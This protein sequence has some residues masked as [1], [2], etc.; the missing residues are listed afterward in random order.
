MTDF[1]KGVEAFQQGSDWRQ[2]FRAN[3]QLEKAR[4][5]A[6]EGGEYDMESRRA[7]RKLRDPDTASVLGQLD[8]NSVQDWQGGLQDPFAYKLMDWFKSHRGKKKRKT[9]AI[10][11][12]G[13]GDFAGSNP[14]GVGDAAPVDPQAAMGDTGSIQNPTDDSMAQPAQTFPLDGY[15]D[16]G[17]IDME[18]LNAKQLRQARW[19]IL[20][21]R[22][23]KAP[24]AARESLTD[25]D[26]AL[27]K[28]VG[29][30]PEGAGTLRRLA[31]GAKGLGEAGALGGTAIITATTPT[32]DYR[33]RFGMETGD[34]SLAGDLTARTLGAASDLGSVL[35]F[36]AADRLYRDKQDQGAGGEPAA[37]SQDLASLPAQGGSG[38][39]VSSIR[40]DRSG[41]RHSALPTQ[42]EPEVADFSDLDIDAKEVP[43][44]KTDDWRK[45]RAQ[46]TDAARKSGK[47]EDVQK[48]GDMVTEMQ[49]KGFL[50]YG[51]QGLA[52]QQAGNTRG[53]MAAYRAAFQY[54]P[55]GNDVE[56]G[57]HKT[58]QGH[59][60]IVGVG[61]DEK[62]GKRVPGTEMIMDPE[63]ISVLMENFKNPAAF[64]MW[65]KDH[66]EDQ[67]R[68]RTYQEVTKPLAQGQLD[69]QADMGGAAAERA[70]ITAQGGAGGAAAQATNMRNAEHAFRERL[71]QMGLVDESQA[72]FLA[73]VMSRIKAA[74]PQVP[75][76]VIIQTIMAA[77][78]DG[79]LEKRLAAMA[80]GAPQAA[81]PRQ[82][83]PTPADQGD[84]GDPAMVGLNPDEIAWANTP[85]Q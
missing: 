34:P 78:K 12:G 15:A 75:D 13:E 45:Y 25:M 64:R 4:D 16:G 33:K 54:F 21:D 6:L 29:R 52:L 85:A 24:G 70:R 48:A 42:G 74:S 19:E 62:T 9:Q 5:L 53:A 44:M 8:P 11:L 84:A 28:F 77:A 83:I 36:G 67:Q 30:A 3:K 59:P 79:S 43:D 57:V 50:N 27:G 40:S 18:A 7:S 71:G 47:P 17:S 61:L 14:Q 26:G 68:E 55:N 49:I 66:R 60:Q 1:M 58:K 80:G 46:V 56:F 51:Q 2:R 31:A 82:A 72:D 35:T 22:L 39:D 81:A 63:R 73:S 37:P 20:K 38:I 23:S 76:N 69:Y 32:E 65:T 10:D 41:G